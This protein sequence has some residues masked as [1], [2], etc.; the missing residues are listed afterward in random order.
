MEAVLEQEKQGGYLEAI[1]ME[2][3]AHTRQA[4]LAF[5]GGGPRVEL[6][7]YV[8]PRG[9]RVASRP[10]DVGFHHVCVVAEDID[11][12]LA[13]LVR[14]GGRPFTDPVAVDTGAN[15]GGRALYVRDPD[16]H[17]VE[18]FQPPPAAG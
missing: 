13:R 17:V 15:R 9:G 10:A 14:A 5:G 4:Q 7:E 2:P 3:G 16:G 8:A 12:V 1:T 6:F 18:L 11:A